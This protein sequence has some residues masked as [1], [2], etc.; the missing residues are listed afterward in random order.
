MPEG[1]RGVIGD[2]NDA[3]FS[4]RKVL[5]IFRMWEL[6]ACC[7]QTTIKE[8]HSP[9]IRI[10]STLTTVQPYMLHHSIPAKCYTRKKC[11]LSL[12]TIYFLFNN[13]IFY[14]KGSSHSQNKIWTVQKC[15]TL[16]RVSYICLACDIVCLLSILENLAG[17]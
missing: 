3:T 11:V 16:F 8:I 17:N 4:I 12:C 1:L 15:M 6:H 14:S 9:G 7:I 5:L 2:V 10:N 13:I